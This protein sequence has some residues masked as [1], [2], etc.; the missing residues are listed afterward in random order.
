MA[1]LSLGRWCADNADTVFGTGSW[2]SNNFLGNSGRSP[3][4]PYRKKPF[5]TDV[6]GRIEYEDTERVQKFEILTTY[7]LF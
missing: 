7:K 1:C 2:K 6:E 5:V 3:I 4:Y